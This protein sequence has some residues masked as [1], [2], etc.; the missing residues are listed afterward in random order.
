[1]Q[2]ADAPEA[3]PDALQ[4]LRKLLLGAFIL[5]AVAVGVLAAGCLVA[6]LRQETGGSRAGAAA[7]G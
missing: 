7:G 4:T 3:L 6:I 1:M 5:F 2:R